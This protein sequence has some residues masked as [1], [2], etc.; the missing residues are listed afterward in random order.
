VSLKRSTIKKL[1]VVNLALAVI[2]STTAFAQYSSKELHR[3][4]KLPRSAQQ[5]R[6]YSQSRGDKILLVAETIRS[7]GRR[8]SE[9]L[10]GHEGHQLQV[11]L[12]GPG[13]GSIHITDS[14]C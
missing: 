5:H 13:K 10:K 7:P 1:C 3:K 9:A 8:K 6:R 4:I 14:K 11:K 12:M 2:L